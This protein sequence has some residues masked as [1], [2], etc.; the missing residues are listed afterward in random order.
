MSSPTKK[1]GGLKAVLLEVMAGSKDTKRDKTKIQSGGSLINQ[2]GK[3]GL[4]R[5]RSLPSSTTQ[6]KPHV[7]GS[8]PPKEKKRNME[9]TEKMEKTEEAEKTETY[10]AEAENNNND[11]LMQE[12]LEKMEK[13]MKKLVSELRERSASCGPEHPLDHLGRTDWNDR[14][15]VTISKDNDWLALD[16]REFFGSSE[17]DLEWARKQVWRGLGKEGSTESNY[18]CVALN[19]K[20]LTRSVNLSQY[21]MKLGP[22]PNSGKR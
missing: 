11:Q 12:K 7:K 8:P 14:F 17:K 3:G 20:L 15:W 21:K 10:E 13:K 9:K 2:K 4:G 18:A 16:Q 22:N 19:S 1:G 5:S 6:K